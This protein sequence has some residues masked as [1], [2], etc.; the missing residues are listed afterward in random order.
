[1]QYAEDE[2]LMLSG[3]QHFMFCPRQWA[4]IHIEQLWDDNRLTAEGNLMH[5]RVDEPGCRHAASGRDVIEMRAMRLAST[6]LGLY[7]VADVVEFHRTDDSH[8]AVRLG[9]KD[10]WWTPVPVE[11]K[12]GRPKPDKRDEVQLAAQAMCL[13]EMFGVDVECGFFYYGATRHRCEVA[14][15]DGLRMLTRRCAA[16]MH[17]LFDSRTT[18][19]PSL[20]PHCRSCSINNWCMPAL[21]NKSDAGVYLENNL[22]NEKTP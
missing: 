12:H 19:P 1:M 5:A 15:D 2:M 14:I 21:Q 17:R 11:Y 8:N 9:G 6:E 10:G 22:Y 3:I 13:G 7:G 18:P 4:L 16:E 20:K